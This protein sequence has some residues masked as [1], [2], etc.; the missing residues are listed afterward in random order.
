MPFLTLSLSFLKLQ[1]ELECFSWNNIILASFSSLKWTY[2][3]STCCLSIYLFSIWLTVISRPEAGK[4][5]KKKKKKRGEIQINW[6]FVF[7]YLFWTNLFKYAE[8]NTWSYYLN[9]SWQITCEIV[10]SQFSFQLWQVGDSLCQL[11]FFFF[12]I[13]KIKNKVH[14]H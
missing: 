8:G 7:F 1:T 14:L 12:N 4:S 9:F 2:M 13:L 10:V 11:F 6:R 3:E 5:K